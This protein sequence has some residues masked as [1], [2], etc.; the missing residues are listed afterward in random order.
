MQVARF[1]IGGVPGLFAPGADR[2]LFAGRLA[3]S[4]VFLSQ[5]RDFSRQR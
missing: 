1:T 5:L 2:K 3:P 4:E